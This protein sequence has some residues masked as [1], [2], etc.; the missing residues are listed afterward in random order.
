MRVY[1]LAVLLLIQHLLA[2]NMSGASSGSSYACTNSESKS[3]AFCDKALSIEKRVADLISRLSLQEKISQLG[4]GAD[5]ISSIDVPAYQWWGEAL[6]GVASSPSVHWDGPVKGATSFPMPISLAA[7]FNKSLWNKIGQVISTEGRAMHNLKQSGLTFWS[8]VIN[9]VRDPRWGRVQ[10]TPGEDPYLIGQYS[11]YFVRG[12]QEAKDYD[13]SNQDDDG[14]EYFA[15]KT[16]ACCKHYTAYDL[17]NWHGIERYY[18]NAEVTKQDLADTYNPP[19]QSCV[20]EGRAS[21]LMCSYNKVN[22]VPTCGDPDLLKGIVRKAWGLRGYI[23][24]DCDS[25]LVMYDQSRY[26]RSPAEAIATAMLA[27]LDLNCG[28]TIKNHGA[29]AVNQSLISED[30]IDRALSNTLTVLM[31]LGIFDGS[32]LDQPYGSLGEDDICS[33][34]HQDLAR[35]AAVQGIVLLKNEE[36]SLPLSPSQIKTLAIIGPNADDKKYTMLGNYAGRPCKY[37]TPLQGISTYHIDTVVFET[38]CSS[39]DCSSDEKIEDAVSAAKKADAV[40][41]VMGLDQDLERET[42]DRNSLKLPGKQEL[43]VSSVANVSSG[44]VVLVLMSGGPLDISWAKTDSKIQSILWMGYSGQAGGLALAQIIFGDRDPVGR[45]PVTWYP[46]TIT[47]WPMTNMNMRPDPDSGYPGRT[48]RFYNGPTVY[49]FGYG[50][51]YSKSTTTEVTAPTNFKAPDL[52][53]QACYHKRLTTEQ[54][55]SIGCLQ[56]DLDAC[57]EASLPMSITVKNGGPTAVTEVVLVYHVPP[58]A[59]EGGTQLKE[60]IAFERTEVQSFSSKIIDLTIN[61]CYHTSTV[62][63]DG[64]RALQLGIHKFVVSS[65]SGTPAEHSFSVQ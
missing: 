53:Q 6:H 37:V 36:D 19:F 41:L 57:M 8:P 43:L 40:I 32:P 34:E 46:E 64:T 59:G 28:S 56:S 47:D 58:R 62:K 15:L 7:S 12:M 21:C 3:W 38:G 25:L 27:G 60:L 22:G 65:G 9:L 61:L 1:V 44:P 26:S 30:D 35:E 4:N 42:F 55:D 17:D 23:V 31:R 16:S 18:F 49:E 5:D 14:N 54:I 13:P 51:S 10:E 11:V 29:T 63:Q 33:D 24:T 52:F 45:L 2:Q 50:M 39:I 48:H 20:Q